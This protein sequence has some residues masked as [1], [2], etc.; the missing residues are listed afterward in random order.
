[1]LRTCVRPAAL[2]CHGACLLLFAALSNPLFSQAAP[3]SSPKAAGSMLPATTVKSDSEAI[4]AMRNVIAQSG[5][6]AAWRE[7]RSVEESFSVLGAG[8]KTPHV[9]LLLD[10]WSLD[11]T[12]YRRKVQGQSTPPSDH[13]GASTFPVNNTGAAQLVA[14]EF[15]QARVLVSRLPAAAAEV[16]LRRSE[17]VLKVSNSPTCKSSDICVDAYRTR[18]STSRPSL[19]Q[20]W[21]ISAATG[22]PI[23]IRYQTT[24]VGHVTGP[25]WREVYFLHYDTEDKIVVPVLIGVNVR[26]HRQAWTLVSLKKNPGFDISKFDSEVAQ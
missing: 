13:N 7:I 25:V 17:Y 10:D 19:D 24:T 20:Q 9:M 2:L 23:T 4:Q 12:R 11:T 22:L 15:D 21:I 6:E 8:E 1:M 3:A 18:D 5:G 14:P 26:G 16:M